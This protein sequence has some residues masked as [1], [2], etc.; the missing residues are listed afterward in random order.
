M[1]LSEKKWFDTFPKG[2]CAN[3][4]IT[5][6]VKIHSNSTTTPSHG[7]D[8]DDDNLTTEDGRKVLSVIKCIRI[9]MRIISLIN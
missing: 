7:T 3:A 2:N 9:K 8:A 4:N 1:V 5:I 6:T